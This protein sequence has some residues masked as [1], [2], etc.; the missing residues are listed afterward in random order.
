MKTLRFLLALAP[1]LLAAACASGPFSRTTYPAGDRPDEARAYGDFM[2]ARVA[3][4]T[5]DPE[6][7]A[8]HYASAIGTAPEEAGVAERAVFSALLAG[9]YEVAAGL[10]RRANDAG[11]EAGLV[12]LTLATDAIARGKNKAAIDLIETSDLRV[13]NR[14]IARNLEAWGLLSEAGPDEAVTLLQEN[15]TGD[16]RLDNVTLHMI[17]LVQTAAGRDA[18]AITTFDMIWAAGARLA[19]GAEAYA[20]LLA[21]RGERD[22]AIALLDQFRAEVGHNAS[23]EALKARLESGATIEPRRLT[24][25][26]G[27]ALALYL[28]ASALMS[29]TNDDIASIYFI[30][31][32]ALDP[33]LQQ[34]RT[35]WAQALLQGERRGE[36]LQ[37]LGEVPQSSPDYAA[38]RSQMASTLLQEDRADDALKLANEALAAK[39]DRGLQLQLASLY[40]SLNRNAE[41]EAILSGIIADDEAEGREDWRVLFA[42]GAARE[43]QSNWTG[44]EADLQA[45][46]VLSPSNATV[47]NYLG[48]S[49]I[50]RGINLD[51]GMNLIRQ[52]VALEPDS[53][54]IVDSLGWAHYRFGE[55]ELAV[56][57][58]ERAVELLPGDAVLND[59]LGDAYWHTGRRKEA[60][61]Q[62][63]RAL[64]LDPEADEALRIEKKLLTGLQMPPQKAV[65][66]ATP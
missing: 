4:L 27:A 33:G 20:E 44:A 60:G 9:D 61:F 64:K 39:P 32:N 58:L 30:L 48:Y 15:L 51:E 28:P 16:P 37:V 3:A 7:A 34:A 8:R 56:D 49:W 18:A 52:A 45:A 55:Y 47:L 22:R 46:L 57:Y 2:I 62:W 26:Q 41:S 21:A 65:A 19:V 38:A 14:M 53:A 54:H 24:T 43:R 10:A 66:S 12:R 31:A 50:D 36:A 6:A 11:S 1:V 59:H 5:N 29:Q 17:G 63:R 42:R 35:Q 13:F 40:Q 23:L 25:R